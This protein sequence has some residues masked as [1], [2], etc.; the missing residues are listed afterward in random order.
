MG[1]ICFPTYAVD[2]K[3]CDA[4]ESNNTTAEVSLTKNIPMTNSGVSWD[5]STTT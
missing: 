4:P 1:R 5:S 2:I 3:E